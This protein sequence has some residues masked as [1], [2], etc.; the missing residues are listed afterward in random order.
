M[1]IGGRVAG[2]GSRG[3]KVKVLPSVGRKLPSVE[4]E[5]IPS[6]PKMERGGGSRLATRERVNSNIQET[7]RGNQSSEFKTHAQRERENKTQIIEKSTGRTIPKDLREKLAMEQVKANPQG[8]TPPRMP[9][10]SDAKN[11]W[12]A[13]DGWVK[14]TQNVNGIEIHY[15]EN[16]KTGQK[17]DFKFK[18]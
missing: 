7:R 5:S 9:P 18:D 3:G 13:Q 16:T 15:I 12:L 17:T 4:V 11:G 14:R 2:N 6:V 8:I 1:P 10:M